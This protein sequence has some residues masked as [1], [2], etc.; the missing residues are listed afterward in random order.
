M[1]TRTLQDLGFPTILA[2]MRAF[3]LSEEG[4]AKLASSEF[5]TDST[6]LSQRQDIIEDLLSLE[7]YG[8]QKPISFP[9]ID[10]IIADLEIPGKSLDGEQLFTLRSYLEAGR[11]FVDYCHTPRKLPS[12]AI[13]EGVS[14]PAMALFEPFD[15]GLHQLYKTIDSTLESPGQVKATHPAI[16]RL[17][18]EVER[19]RT[20]R[21][22]FSTDYLKKQQTDSSSVQP[23]FR[24]GRVVLPIRNDQRAGLEGVIHSSSASGVTVYMEPYRLVELNNQVVMAQQQIQIEIARIL[25][26][27]SAQ[28]R[29]QLEIIELLRQQVGYADSLY[30]R[31]RYVSRYDCVRPIKSTS[32]ELL[33]RQARHPLLRDKAVPISIDL[34]ASIKAVVISGPN[35]GGKT[36]TIKTVALFALLHQFLY[37]VP[38]AE[39]TQIPLFGSIYT[40]VGDEQ[41]IEESLSTFSGH[42]RNIGRI[43]DV[44]DKNSLIIFDELG[45][46]TD[47]VEGSALARAILEYCVERAALTLVTS[48]HSV[49][50]QYAYAQPHLLN[51]SMEFDGDTHEPTFRVISGVPGE[52]HALETA[53]RMQVPPSVLAQ[54]MT[55]IGAEMVEISTI[56]KGLEEKRREAEA[57]EKVLLERERALQE[58]VRK[59][60]L[61]QLRLAQDEQ[62]VRTQQ[63][64]DL[65][66]FISDKR[67]ELENLVSELR[68]GEI[69][70]TKTRKVKQFIA[71]LEQKKDE[72]KQKVEALEEVV[73]EEAPATGPFA[74]G[75]DVLAGPHRREGR[76]VRKEKSGKWVVAIGPM[77]FTLHE[78]ELRSLPSQRQKEQKKVSISYESRTVAPQPVIDVRGMTLDEALEVVSV[79]IE[80]AL[81]HSIGSFSVIH[82]LG[83]GILSRGIHDYLRTVPQVST[84]YFARPEDGGYGKT[85][86]EF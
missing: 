48:H 20:E 78:R 40:D 25:A 38:A 79:Q 56:I 57:R 41:S 83:D 36:V 10:E 28:V 50:K 9:A 30:A 15:A 52:S 37:F 54:A 5:V 81:V 4:S 49:L 27:L 46:G 45:S 47:P 22:S 19:K 21:H 58:Q 43:L 33:L 32:G 80:G 51:A 84:Y 66:R 8:V 60:D 64:G 85:Y 13:Q 7:S 16:A 82:G 24:D 68:E 6:L 72:S 3:C 61:R 86:I 53:K 23:A 74:V 14:T 34:D 76:I 55:Y 59:L 12:E 77:K 75:M 42:M 11:V 31:S 2:E 62:L 17:T 35:A 63:L 69:S 39:G 73:Q 67:S 44:C 71:S 70:K 18:R 65:S 29:E 1:E 26:E